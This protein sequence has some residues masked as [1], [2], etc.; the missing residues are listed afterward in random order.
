MWNSLTRESALACG[1]QM[2]MP[3]LESR[4]QLTQFT[5]SGH[6]AGY[7]S[8]FYVAVRILL[9]V[10]GEK[11]GKRRVQRGFLAKIMPH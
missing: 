3:A 2:T 4:P 9:T 8:D 11:T 5:E 1:F 6:V 10:R 7:F